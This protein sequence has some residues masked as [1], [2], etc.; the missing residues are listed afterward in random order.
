MNRRGVRMT[1]EE[2]W[3]AKAV[4][5]LKQME[6][7][8]LASGRRVNRWGYRVCPICGSDKHHADS[9]KLNELLKEAEKII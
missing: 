2:Q 3:I 9:C 1:K 5:L 8:G 4:T 7:A 6:Y